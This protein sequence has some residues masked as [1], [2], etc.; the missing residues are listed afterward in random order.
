MSLTEAL[1]EMAEQLGDEMTAD[2]V[3]PRFTC[4]EAD[5]VARVLAL[6]GH[7]AAA[8]NFLFGHAS[9]DEDE[10]THFQMTHESVSDYI[11]DDLSV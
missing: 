3:G 1:H 8:A 5:S 4:T 2:M 6:S 11:A 9:E 7:Q 10:D